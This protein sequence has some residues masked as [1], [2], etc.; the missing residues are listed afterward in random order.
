MTTPERR[1]SDRLAGELVDTDFQGWSD[2]TNA[3][4]DEQAFNDV[5]GS[6]L[7]SENDKVRVWNIH[8][9]PGQRLGAHRHRFDYFWSAI[10]DGE[11]I[12]HSDDGT[13]RRVSYRAGDTRHFDFG[14]NE[15]LLHDLENVGTGP[16]V[17][18]TVEHKPQ[19]LPAPSRPATHQQRTLHMPDPKVPP[20]HRYLLEQALFAHLATIRPD[21]GPQ[22]SV[23]W[24]DWDGERIRLSHTTTRQKYRNMVQNPLVSMHFQDPDD[25]YRT[26][27]VR[28]RVESITPD[29]DTAFY[30]RLQQRYNMITP[31][32]D[33]DV[34]VVI[35]I[36]PTAFVTVDGGLTQRETAALT[37]LI[38]RLVGD[39]A[40]DS[41]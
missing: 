4:F 14:P 8:L 31:I 12:Q 41:G 23:M 22:S 36:A 2:E 28:G 21:G 6:A 9:A 5:V 33:A 1:G 34:R 26:L 29:D 10:T 16:L 15:Y 30:Q 35:T 38:E 3:D 40:S 37:E 27:E 39:E 25:P 32:F 7:L 24:F 19:G 11:S 17:F 13:T 20:S 18:I